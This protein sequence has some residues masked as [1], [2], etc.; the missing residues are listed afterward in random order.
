M[1]TTPCGRSRSRWRAI[2]AARWPRP[3][4]GEQ[5][6]A[7][8]DKLTPKLILLDYAMPGMNG[9]QLARALRE[10]GVTAP[11]AL[12]TGYAELSEADVAAGELAGLLRK[13]FTIRELQALLTQ[14]RAARPSAEAG[15]SG[16][17]WQ[18][19]AVYQT[20]RGNVATGATPASRAAASAFAVSKPPSAV[21]SSAPW[22]PSSTQQAARSTPTAPAMSVRSESPTASTCSG[23]RPSC[24]QHRLID[25]RIGLAQRADIAA[26]F[27]VAH[28]QGAGAQHAHA[29][30]D[31]LQVGI[32]ADHLQPVPRALRQDR[33]EFRHVAGI[34][35]IVRAGV[36]HEIR[37]GRGVAT[38]VSGSP[39]STGRSR[40]GPRWNTRVPSSAHHR[41]GG[42]CSARRTAS[43]L[44]RMPV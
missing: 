34:A 31:D 17:G 3:S 22:M 25:R 2:L 28:R 29:A 8:V 21:L 41:S 1:T 32:G 38:T 43:P 12:V 37:F 6:L 13:P 40:S 19:V 16:T 23:G 20:K 9:L 24:S 14:L 42:S 39:S 26:K 11:I 27:A 7:L 15:L 4:G 5:A 10:R 36:Q 33:L 30:A 18:A 44:V 35:M